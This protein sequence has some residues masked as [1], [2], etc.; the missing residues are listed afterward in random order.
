MP[1][2]ELMGEDESDSLRD[3]WRRTAGEIDSFRRESDLRRK[4]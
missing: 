3:L 1:G 4:K 2:F